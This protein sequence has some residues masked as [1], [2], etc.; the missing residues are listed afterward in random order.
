MMRRACAFLAALA[1][2]PGCEVAETRHEAPGPGMVLVVTISGG[3]APSVIPYRPPDVAVY[4]NGRIV[5]SERYRPAGARTA[6]L[7]PGA[8]ER[9]VRRAY[10]L[11][12]DEPRRLRSEVQVADGFTLSLVFVH[13]G[14]RSVTTAEAGA[15][16]ADL[17]ELADGLAL[18]RIPR[19]DLRSEPRPYRPGA[20]AVLA[21]PI[22]GQDDSP[23]E[24]PLPSLDSRLGR[25]T[26]R[27][28]RGADAA[29]ASRMITTDR[30][31]YWLVNGQL[32]RLVALPLLPGEHTC[33]DL[34]RRP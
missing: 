17:K 3:L 12:L 34:A 27:V 20:T 24:W 7:T 23:R 18:N 16:S 6:W 28:L 33:A 26:C 5:E 13:D 19:R 25:T 4:G 21:E 9:I 8:V 11:G 1:F 15:E 30:T 22:P 10:D 29:R 2:L 31:P 32:N 14:K